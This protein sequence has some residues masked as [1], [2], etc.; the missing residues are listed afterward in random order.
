MTTPARPDRK[1]KHKLDEIRAP[2]QWRPTASPTR[3][4]NMA[5]QK[6]TAKALEQSIAHWKRLA[7]GKRRKNENISTKHCALCKLFYEGHC[8]GCPVAIK[9]KAV[10]CQKS[11]WVAACVAGNHGSE[12]D[13]PVF[14]RAA[15]REL[16]FLEGLRKGK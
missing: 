6:E 15:R 12:L 16:A 13:E 2:S 4:D 5:T 3:K 14:H 10:H 8:V 1:G 9:T 7:T 11:P